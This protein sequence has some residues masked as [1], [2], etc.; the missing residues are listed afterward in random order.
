METRC[1]GN[2]NNPTSVLRPSGDD[3]NG[4]RYERRLGPRFGFGP[5]GPL[6]T[7]CMRSHQLL[8]GRK[9]EKCLTGSRRRRILRRQRGQ[10]HQRPAKHPR[11]RQRSRLCS[12]RRYTYVSCAAV[13]GTG[14]R[15]KRSGGAG[16]WA[17]GGSTR[18]CSLTIL[19]LGENKR[20]L[21]ARVWNP[22][23]LPAWRVGDDVLPGK[24]RKEGA[25]S[26]LCS[27]YL[28]TPAVPNATQSPTP[29]GAVAETALPPLMHG[30]I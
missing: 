29:D 5:Y 1:K 18:C 30:I 15:K 4:G 11:H 3:I 2:M 12:P 16:G 9:S 7:A 13:G 27:T 17:R 8:L 26:T 19:L 6:Y 24:G 22:N 23:C 20:F 28:D 21:H 10:A 25:R 14:T